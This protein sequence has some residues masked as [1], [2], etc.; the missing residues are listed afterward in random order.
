VTWVDRVSNLILS[1]TYEF[2]DVASDRIVGRKSHDFRGDNDAAW[3]HT[4]TRM[5]RDLQEKRQ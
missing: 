2:H 5:V 4:I 1:L 3:T